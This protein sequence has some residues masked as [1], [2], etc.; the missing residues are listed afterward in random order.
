MPAI[1]RRDGPRPLPLQG[2]D[3]VTVAPATLSC[4]ALTPILFSAGQ[5]LFKIAGLRHNA[6]PGRSIL[7]ILTDPY[8]LLALA[9]YGVGTLVWVYVL[10]KMPLRQAYPA[11]AVTYLLVPLASL[12]IFGET[13]T[14]S[15][16]IGA[17]LVILG[18]LVMMSSG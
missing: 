16:W 6:R 4:L 11:M 5:V 18:V 8:L 14:W 3:R 15:Y 2:P 12:G 13:I 9:I 17:G 7:G 10:S 1:P